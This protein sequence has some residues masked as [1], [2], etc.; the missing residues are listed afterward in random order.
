MQSDSS[1][2]NFETALSEAIKLHQNKKFDE[3][4]IAFKHILTRNDLSLEQKSVVNFNIALSQYAK[5]DFAQ[6]YLFAKKAE[7]ISPLN[8]QAHELLQEI[9]KAY[10]PKPLTQQ[11]N[12][13]EVIQQNTL[14][15]IPWEF[16]AVLFV[17]LT[18]LTL[19]SLKTWL[20][21]KAK[22]Q[23]LSEYA[24]VWPIKR[25]G[26]VALFLLSAIAFAVK[27]SEVQAAKGLTLAEGISLQ[28]APGENQ[29]QIL[30]IG[31]GILVQILDERVVNTEK[32]YKIKYL[33]GPAGWVKSSLI[34]SL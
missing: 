6:S 1:N 5:K 7:L 34:E 22:A 3:A 14:A 29:A 23:A 32:Y 27:T 17:A 9:K 31:S 33:G 8:F 19:R 16:I 2:L 13:L 15:Q 4:T 30:E 20:F 10:Q 24:P 26:L 18:F 21:E 25:T 28:T 11:L 12:F